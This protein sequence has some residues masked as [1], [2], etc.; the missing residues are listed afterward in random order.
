MPSVLCQSVRLL[1]SGRFAEALELLDEALSSRAECAPSRVSSGAVDNEA[2]LRLC[3]SACSLGLRDWTQA[4]ADARFLTSLS[5]AA[6][7]PPSLRIQG[8]QRLSEALLQSGQTQQALDAC[9]EGL[10][11]CPH[12]SLVALKQISEQ[13]QRA[14]QG[15]TEEDWVKQHSH[16][17]DHGH[18]H[19]HHD[20]GHS[21]DSGHSHAAAA[22]SYMGT[23]HTGSIHEGPLDHGHD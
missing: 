1:K 13:C 21:H 15:V 4:I 12:E 8:Y 22:H 5:G 17:H 9:A 11:S 10:A 14:L 6:T 3:R 7:A 23:S 16:S 2:E 18:G 20:H 19:S